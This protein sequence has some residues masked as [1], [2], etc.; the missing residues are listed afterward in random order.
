MFV[1]ATLGSVLWGSYSLSNELLEPF[2]QDTLLNAAVSGGIAGASQAIVAAPAE[3]V[4]ILLE[5]GFGGHSWSCAWKE[6]FQVRKQVASADAFPSKLHDVRRLRGWFNEVRQMAGQGWN[7]WGWGCSKDAVGFASFFVIFEISRRAATHVKRTS[8]NFIESSSLISESGSGW[9]QIPPI[10]NGMTLVGGGVFHEGLKSWSCCK[11]VNKPVLDF[12]E[13]MSIQGCTELPNHTSEKPKEVAP[14]PKATVVQTASSVDESG[15]ETFGVQSVAQAAQTAEKAPVQPSEPTLDVDDLNQAVPPGTQCKRAGCTTTFVDDETNRQG[16]GEGTVCHFHPLP[17]IFREGSKVSIFPEL[18]SL[19]QLI[20]KQGYLCCKRRVLEFEEFLKIPGCKTGRHCFIPV[21][22][23]PLVE[24]EVNCRIDHYQTP[25][26]VHV[27]VFAK[28][29]DKERSTVEFRDEEVRMKAKTNSFLL[30]YMTAKISVQ[31]YL[32]DKKRFTKTLL[33]FGPIEPSASSFRIL[34]TKVE[35][36]L[37]KKDG[38]SW[39]VLEKTDKNLGN[40]SLTF[41]VGGRT[42]TVG[43]KEFVLDEKNQGRA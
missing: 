43:G 19:A 6:V 39:T 36:T 7:G 9:R 10:L 24:E 37:Q 32:P 26:Q 31:L 18:L 40:I 22:N 34:G 14:P 38:R 30:A 25:G 28:K 20:R 8:H 29:V 3:N 11:D 12:E 33:L 41:G 17:P 5:H 15:K 42:G 2:L 35:L 23:N 4:R 21:V 16:D 27:S 13:F 1:N